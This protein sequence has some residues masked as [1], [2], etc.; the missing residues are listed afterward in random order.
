MRR[1]QWP[2]GLRRRSAAALL[3]RLWVQIPQAAWM[4]VVSVV[5]SGRGLCDGLITHPEESYRLWCVVE[6]D[7][8]ISWMRRPWP[9]GDCCA[10]Q[11]KKE[12]AVKTL[13]WYA[14]HFNNRNQLKFIVGP[15]IEKK[16]T[17][18]SL[19]GVCELAIDAWRQQEQRGH[20]F[21]STSNK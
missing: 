2:S 15:R 11:K 4:S 3:L 1:S 21:S 10:K 7:L 12:G 16:P 17:S 9:I 20:K 13:D 19:P 5:L 6:Y 18:S 14:G 8:E